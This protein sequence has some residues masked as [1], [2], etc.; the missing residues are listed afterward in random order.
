MNYFLLGSFMLVT[1]AI[2]IYFQL[3][4]DFS[5]PSP[6]FEDDLFYNFV[7]TSPFINRIKKV[8][9]DVLVEWDNNNI[10]EVK[11]FI[12]LYKNH[13]NTDK[14]TWILRNI[15][16]NKKKN[17]LV[18]R[19]MIDNRYH[20]TILS[21][22]KNKN[23]KDIVSNVG[24][25]IL[26]SEDKE[27]EG[28][29]YT[30]ENDIDLNLQKEEIN[31]IFV[32]NNNNAINAINGNNAINNNNISNNAINN[33]NISNN[34]IN[35]NNIS[36]NAISNNAIN[37]NKKEPPSPTIDCNGKIKHIKN[38]EDLERAEIIHKCK[39][40]NEIDNLADEVRNYRPFS[41]FFI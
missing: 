20:I 17:K 5:S 6:S 24:R 15:K 23:N 18:L 25:I 9:S 1:I 19:D 32:N 3:K 26:F 12:V 35:N 31:N 36:N 10:K 33:N 40:D 28:F 13:D 41:S 4:E 22:H 38:R 14:S 21:V 34:A 27:Y 29:Q 39:N 16:S 8:D 7:P 11:D 2:I 30:K 37:D